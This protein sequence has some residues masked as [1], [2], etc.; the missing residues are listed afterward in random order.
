MVCSV[1]K[2]KFIRTKTQFGY[3]IQK[4]IMNKELEKHIDENFETD[5]GGCW[6]KA[7]H[8]SVLLLLPNYKPKKCTIENCDA[9]I[10][11]HCFQK[12]KLCLECKILPALPEQDFY[13][14]EDLSKEQLD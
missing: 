13:N 7:L 2:N 4:E 1:C 10:C 5:E 9:E 6:E 11:N 14:I 3:M 8:M 12:T